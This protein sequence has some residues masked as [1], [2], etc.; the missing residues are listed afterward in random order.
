[1]SKNNIPKEVQ[2]LLGDY[3]TQVNKALPD[4]LEGFYLYGS[5]ALGAY[6][7]GKSDLDFVAVIKRPATLQD[8]EQLRYIHTQ[9]HDRYALIPMDGAYLQI[10]DLGKAPEELTPYPYFDGTLHDAGHYDVNL[11]T[12]WML[13]HHGITVF[14]EDIAPDAL[15]VRWAVL[16]EKM[17]D[18]LNSYWSKWA[19]DPEQ[20]ALLK[21]DGAIVWAVLGILR[22][23]YSF[24]EQGITS[25]IG[26]GEYALNHL[27]Q[28]WHPL[29]REA[30][31]LRKNQASHYQ[32]VAQRQ[33]E[34]Q[35]FL[36]MVIARCNQLINL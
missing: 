2:A 4:F 25:K 6:E 20:V 33:Q 5:I 23:Y 34:A 8:L 27:P 17:H 22:L 19:N 32:D 31:A 1:M 18:N 12:W 26:A 24:K 3:L 11:V 36:Q 29:I 16:E 9:L 15:T 35:Q 21:H 14:G 28:Q 10:S 7:H 13:E 30:L